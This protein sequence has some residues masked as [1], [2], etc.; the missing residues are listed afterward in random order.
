ML[1]G[2]LFCASSVSAGSGAWVAQSRGLNVTQSQWHFFSEALASGPSSVPGDATVT[3]VH[4]RYHARPSTTALKV[5]LCSASRVRCERLKQE[6]GKTKA[7]E[8][9]RAAQAF[10]LRFSMPGNGRLRRDVHIDDIQV[11]VNY[12]R[13]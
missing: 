11:I 5:E 7:F 6:A 3:S 10:Q 2:A 13:R 4:W 12:R 1:A 9:E 8:G